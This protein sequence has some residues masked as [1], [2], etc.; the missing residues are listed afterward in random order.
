MRVAFLGLG[1]MG[2]A[3]ATNLVKVGND[4][5]VW[6]RSKGKSVEGAKSAKSPKEAAADAD[7][8]WICVSD[9]AAVE[10][11]LFGK[12]GAFESVR[13]GMLVVDSSTILPE[14]S[15]KFAERIR[16]RGA[17]FVDAPVTGSKIGAEAG[18]LIFIAGGKDETIEKLNPLFTA[19]GKSVIRMGE[20]GKGLAAKLA[21]NLMIALIY[22]GF[23]E[24]LTLATKLGVD[25]QALF[26][27]IQSSMV[28]SGVV[29]YKMPFV[30]KRDFSPNFPLRLMHKDIRLM[31][32]AA[33]DSGVELPGLETVKEIY[34][35]AHEAG[36]DDLDY[37]ATLL[38]VEERAGVKKK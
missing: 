15:Q 19:M 14:A 3:M 23:A 25:Q 11:V 27:L 9:T 30:E 29:D 8:L 28:R 6:N 12:D 16:E 35:E 32:E 22:E 36:R 34:D 2:R 17:D 5:I 37:A 38:N 7:V 1:I 24:A 31:L 33:R 26:S 10:Q 13:S 4:V 21:M 18:T 20:N